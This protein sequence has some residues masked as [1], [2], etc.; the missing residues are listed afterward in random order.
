M[1]KFD[2]PIGS[3]DV[4]VL[5]GLIFGLIDGYQT[6]HDPLTVTY[7]LLHEKT[8]FGYLGGAFLVVVNLLFDAALWP[9]VV[10]G[11]L[12]SLIG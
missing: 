7:H 1:N 9:L 2:K 12:L 8:L 6:I 10:I 4:Y 11:W 5:I 3:S